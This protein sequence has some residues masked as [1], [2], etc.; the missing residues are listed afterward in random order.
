MVPKSC[1][2]YLVYEHP[3]HLRRLEASLKLL[4]ENFTKKNPYPIVFGH[5]GLSKEAKNFIRK[6]AP[7]E[8]DIYFKQV[9]FSL[10]DY[11]EEILSKIPE[12]FVW[13]GIWDKNAFFSMGYRHMCRWF[14]GAMYL[15]PFFD[16]VDYVMRLDSDSYIIDNIKNDPFQVMKDKDAIYG[17]VDTFVDDENVIVGLNDFCQDIA[18]SDNDIQSNLAYETNFFIQKCSWFK[19]DKWMNFFKPIDESGY[20][21]SRRWG[22]APIHYQGIKRLASEDKVIKIDIPYHHGGDYHDDL[23]KK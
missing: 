10:P 2:Y 21:Y 5:E 6:A 14:S 22:D 19:S 9:D 1:I 8:V 11:S 17:W 15:D 3:I 16:K 20:I 4:S 18:P 13:D 12:K 7:I 23:L